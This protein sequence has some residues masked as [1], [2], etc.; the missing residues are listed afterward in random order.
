MQIRTLQDKITALSQKGYSVIKSSKARKLPVNPE[1]RH[2]ETVPDS[3]TPKKLNSKSVVFYSP[4]NLSKPN[5]FSKI[6]SDAS[7]LNNTII[8]DISASIKNFFKRR[9][10]KKEKNNNQ[11]QDGN[12]NNNN[13]NILPADILHT[14]GN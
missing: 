8:G 9:S 5:H 13:D 1:D 11:K 14:E 7:R 12:N 4:R 6:D 2:V 10:N 3:T